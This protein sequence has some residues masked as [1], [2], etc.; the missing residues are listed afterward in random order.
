MHD[1]EEGFELPFAS[2]FSVR[3]AR[4]PDMKPIMEMVS[5]LF[6][7]GA[8]RH[9]PSDRY[10]LAERSGVPVGFCHFR[11]REKK[12]Y[13]A[14][15]GVLPQYRNHGVGSQLMAE[16]LYYADRHGIQ[17]TYL[18]VRALNS[19]A[20]LYLQYGFFEKRSGDVL[21]LVRKRPS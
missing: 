20:S 11:L 19:A 10:L 21:L 13:I 5:L 2:Q 16:A 6:P 3:K 18:K 15:L 4:K 7:D 1:E 12:C 17:T 8:A 14:G 9:L